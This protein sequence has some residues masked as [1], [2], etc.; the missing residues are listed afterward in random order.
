MLEEPAFSTRIASSIASRCH[1]HCALAAKSCDKH[2]YGTRGEPRHYGVSPANENDWNA[3]PHHNARGVRIRKER[4]TFSQ[5]IAS[6]EVGHYKDVG[7]PCYRRV[8]LL[9]LR[10]REVDRIV[11]CERAVK[12]ASG[13]LATVCHFAQSTGFDR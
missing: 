4:Q 11:Q 8:D 7:L 1:F 3:P 5:H 12:N 10:C 2:S 6:F 13:D 9:D